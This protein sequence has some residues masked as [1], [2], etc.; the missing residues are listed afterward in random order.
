MEDV[1]ANFEYIQRSNDDRGYVRVKS[2]AMGCGCD[3]KMAENHQQR[4]LRAYPE[5]V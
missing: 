1:G 5:I 3:E 2:A 4:A